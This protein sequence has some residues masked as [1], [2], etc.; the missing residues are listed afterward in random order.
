MKRWLYIALCLL[1]VG[2]SAGAHTPVA[3]DTVGPDRQAV[4]DSIMA[5]VLERVPLHARSVEEYKSDLYLK[6]KVD[7]V[8]RNA[9][10]KLL[11][12]M[13]RLRRGVNEYLMETYSEL[14]YTYPD[15]FDHHVHAAAGTASEFW[16]A[17]GRLLEY[18]RINIYSPTLLRDKLISPLSPNA[19]RYYLFRLEDTVTKDGTTTY[20]ISFTP[21]N[22]SFQLMSGYMTVSA[23]SWSVRAIRFKGRSELFRFDNL[24]TMGG[25]G[26][27]SEL[28]PVSCDMHIV[29]R[30]LGNKFTGDYVAR[31]IYK[32]IQ[33]RTPDEQD[34]NGRSRYDLTE[35]YTLRS[36]TNAARRD[37]AYFD[38]LRP[39]ALTAD[40]R[41]LYEDYFKS[42]EAKAVP[43]TTVTRSKSRAVW[44]QVGDALI[45]RY[46]FD[47]HQYGKVRVSPLVNP[48]LVSY[49]GSNG[50]S[51]RLDFKYNR[52][53]TRGRL[54][55]VV[56][57]IGYN[58]T[59][60]KFYW[61]VKADYDYWPQKRSAW[62]LTAGSG[63]RIYSS[64][65]VDE[66]KAIADSLLD[67]D[68]IHL[69]YFNDLYLNVSHSWEMVN[70]LTLDVGISMH[71]RTETNRTEFVFLSGEESGT[72][73]STLYADNYV[74]LR[75]Y[76]LSNYHHTYNSFAPSIKLTW[77]PGQYYYMGNGRKV[78]LGSRYPTFSVA[79]E[80]G[81]KG[82]LSNSVGYERLELDAQYHLS[83]G[84]MR[85]LY[86][87]AGYGT[88]LRSNETYFVDY[89]NLKR[90]N[91]PTGWADDI[92]GVFQL[93]DSRWYNSSL[94]YVRANAV[95]ESPFLLLRHARGYTR[96]VI[97]ERLYLNLL[98]MP[99]LNPYVEVGYGIGTH[100]FDFGLF[101]SF[102]NGEYEEVGVKFTFELFNR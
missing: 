29:F 100:V 67:F 63:N 21:R 48:L 23:G 22:E 72:T 74:S 50:W 28:L 99:H 14:H 95:Y 47:L 68:K 93:L 77:T 85:R 75:D 31:M 98:F 32:D 12:T 58:F 55:R 82:I 20:R 11:P 26:E 25:L 64:D 61:R 53:L 42:R 44:G 84:L 73:R 39:V 17:D 81:I 35:S 90:S 88:F 6:G 24:V 52:L 51:Y 9:I 78:N 18:F 10:A 33:P 69:D 7:V 56:P 34:D 87:R 4:A 30:F 16:E 91:L 66:L 37:S 45:S 2:L 92:G 96:N 27:E 62:H 94:E 41:R 19:R 101:A 89:A 97:S 43:D 36:D 71:R 59:Q 40:E 60:R 3:V 1:T 79:Y 83:L 70:G 5:R 76:I 86:L 57:Y 13:F 8:K 102:A 80:R 38:Q 49:S 15:Q 65:V 54:L 46:S